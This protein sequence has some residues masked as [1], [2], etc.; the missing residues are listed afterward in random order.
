VN[1]DGHS[2]DLTPD[3]RT[4]VCGSHAYD[5]TAVSNTGLTEIYTIKLGTW[6]L[7]GNQ[8]IGFHQNSTEDDSY[9]GWSVDIDADGER[10]ITSGPYD[11]YNGT[12]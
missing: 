4:I 9:Y 6:Q 10:V 11:G 7:K 8:I 2:F 1:S 5:S 12:D 3:G